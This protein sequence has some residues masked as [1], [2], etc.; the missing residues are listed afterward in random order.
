MDPDARRARRDALL[1]EALAL[2][3]AAREAF[4]DRSCD[5]P[6]LRREIES[7]LNHPA[8]HLGQV[9]DDGAEAMF[10]RRLSA[11]DRVGR[12]IIDARVGAGGM[13][14]VYRAHDPVIEREVALKIVTWSGSDEQRRRRF[15]AELRLLGRIIHDHVV[16]VYDFG[17]HNGMPY[18]VTELLDGEDLAAA[19]AGRRCGDIESRLGIARQ[20]ASALKDVHAAGILHRDI[21]PANVFIEKSGRAKLLDFGIARDD[22]ADMKTA[23][24]IAGTPGYLAPEQLQGA[25]ATVQ[26]DVYAF[27]VVL[28]ELFSGQRLYRGTLAQVLWAVAHEPI[29]LERLHECPSALVDLV[30]QCTVKDPAQRIQDFDAVARLLNGVV[31][32]PEVPLAAGRARSSADRDVEVATLVIPSGNSSRQPGFSSRRIAM[33]AAAVVLVLSIAGVVVWMNVS[34]EARTPAV[35]N[36]SAPVRVNPDT[37]A[38]VAAPPSNPPVTPPPAAAPPT[39]ADSLPTQ[40]ARIAQ[41][42]QQGNFAAALAELDRV[43]PSDDPRVVAL[44]RSVAQAAARSM[45]VAL[46]AAASQKAAELA[47]VT[48]AEAEKARLIAGAASSRSDYVHGGRQALVAADAYRRAESEA[49]AAAAAKPAKSDAPPAT[50]A[51][52]PAPI[53]EAS[54]FAPR[55]D[56]PAATAPNVAAVPGAGTLAGERPGIVRALQRYQDAH[57][58]RNLTALRAVYPNIPQETARRL[59]GQFRGCRAYDVSFGSDPTIALRENDPTA[60]TAT[61]QATYLCLSATTPT[62]DHRI[63]RDVFSVRKTAG[64]WLIERVDD[65]ARQ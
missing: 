45:D 64:E 31:V 17:E 57:A 62:P 32:P 54:A 24:L 26:S 28:F 41:L 9:L 5:S 50:A 14:D 3:G 13:G 49:R 7:L 39:V 47:P 46:A 55:A 36:A 60:A 63:V 52:S 8:D 40:L 61:V 42:N 30:R 2:D 12:Y 29:P 15:F 23:S 48:Y 59:E 33:V 38:Q 21:K 44:A 18:L 4:L 10:G 51:A 37:P 22:D 20:M 16:R 65:A 19:I 43:S 53:P 1:E 35:A 6:S 27:G 58:A 34:D 25:A 56:V 11:G